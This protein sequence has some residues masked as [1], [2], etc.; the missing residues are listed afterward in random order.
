M[1]KELRVFA[2]WDASGLSLMRMGQSPLNGGGWTR[3]ELLTGVN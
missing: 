1:K 2:L 3:S